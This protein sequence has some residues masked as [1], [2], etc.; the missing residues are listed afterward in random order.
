[1]YLLVFAQVR[2]IANIYFFSG[3]TTGQER[4]TECVLLSTQRKDK[5]AKKYG[6]DGDYVA[7]ANIAAFTKVAEAM[8]TQGVV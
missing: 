1:M 6:L 2:I 3:T 8:E 5:A 4:K 7:G